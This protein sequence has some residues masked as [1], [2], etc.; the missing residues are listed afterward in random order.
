MDVSVGSVWIIDY[1]IVSIRSGKFLNI[2]SSLLSCVSSAHT[3]INSSSVSASDS[4][5]VAL[6]LGTSPVVLGA[7]SL[8][9]LSISEVN[10]LKVV[11][12]LSQTHNLDF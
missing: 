4:T 9:A 8:S 12:I 2:P 6:F 7:S 11:Y 1:T 5:C 3:D 10:R